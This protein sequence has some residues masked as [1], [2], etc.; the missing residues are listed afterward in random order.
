MTKP[1]AKVNQSFLLKYKGIKWVCKRLGISKI[2][3]HVTWKFLLKQ[4]K[5]VVGKRSRF[6]W[7]SK[8]F[9]GDIQNM[10]KVHKEW[11]KLVDIWK[12]Q[13]CRKNWRA[14]VELTQ[15]KNQDTFF[16]HLKKINNR[17]SVR[18]RNSQW[19]IIYPP[20]KYWNEID[21]KETIRSILLL[22]SSPNTLLLFFCKTGD[23]RI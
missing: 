2:Q 6:S 21:F 19:C 13:N 17:K 7:T 20:L 12:E 14:Q 1:M 3:K 18:E 22:L 23:V 4:M 15:D 5:T 11:K 9:S 8:R 16:N 10:Q